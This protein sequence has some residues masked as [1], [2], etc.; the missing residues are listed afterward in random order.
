MSE[1]AKYLS[2]IDA[3][4]SSIR[5]STDDSTCILQE[6]GLVGYVLDERTENELVRQA[7]YTSFTFFFS[8][9]SALVALSGVGGKEVGD[10]LRLRFAEGS[11]CFDLCLANIAMIPSL[12]SAMG[13]M[14]LA[15]SVPTLPISFG[16]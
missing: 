2:R 5:V 13:S 6:R 15:D 10:E 9:S 14:N 11:T 16:T 7:R 4:V 3:I 1:S 12:R 8:C